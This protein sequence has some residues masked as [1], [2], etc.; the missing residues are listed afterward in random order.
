MDWAPVRF[1]RMPRRPTHPGARRRACWFAARPGAVGC[2]P[3][4]ALLAFL[5]AIVL[6]PAA[7]HAAVDYLKDIKPVLHQ[8][9]LSCHGALRQKAG[10][11]LDTA[12]LVR[13]G[14]SKGVVATPSHPDGSPLLARVTTADPD[15]RMPPDGGPLS[16]EQVSALRQW[17]AE[18]MTG[19]SDEVAEADP[20]EHWSFKKPVRP[21]LPPIQAPD[22]D[23]HPID[24]FV[25]AE[26]EARGLEPV[27]PAT[28]EVLLRRVYIDLVGY[29]PTRDELHAFLV[30][31]SDAAY[32][33]VV[34]RLLASPAHGERWARHWMDVWRYADWFGRRHVPDVWNSAPQ[35]FRWRDW[36]VASLNADKGY[37]QMGRE[38]LAADEVRPGDDEAGVATGYLVRNWYALNPNQWMRETVEHTAK[39]FL[40]L[41][42]NCAHCHDHKYDPITQE[43][44]FRFRAFFEPMGLRQD[45][46]LGEPDPGPFQKYEYSALRRV[47]KTGSVRVLDEAAGAPTRLYRGGDERNVASNVP[48]IRPGV[49]A[50]LGGPALD[51][52][53]VPLPTTAYYPGLR[54]FVRDAEVAAR[55]TALQAAVSNLT[56]LSRALAQGPKPATNEP[57]QRA[58]S[59][60][61]RLSHDLAIDRARARVRAAEADAESLRR[62]IAAAVAAHDGTPPDAAAALASEASRAE[63]HHA[64]CKADEARIAATEA[65]DLLRAEQALARARRAAMATPDKLVKDEAA[66]EEA[67]L[68]KLGEEVAARTQAAQRA[69]ADAA[70]NGVAFTPLSPVYPATSTGRRRAL[71]HWIF[72]KDNPLAAR[73][74]VNHVWMRHFRSPLV[75]TVFDL[76]RNGSPPTHPALLDW[77]AV[78]LME[79]GWSLKHLHR[80]IVT[81]RTYRLASAP[82]PGDPAAAHRNARDPDNAFL[83]RMNPGHMEAEVLRDALLRLAGTLDATIGGYPVPNTEAETSRRRTLYLECFPEDGG[84][85]EFTGMFDPPDPTDCYRRTTTVMPQQALALSN[86]RIARQQAEAI[87]RRLGDD[88]AREDAPHPPGT[89]P[90][91][92]APPHEAHRRFIG[93]AFEHVLGRSPSPSESDAAMRFLASDA[94]ATSASKSVAPHER[95]ASEGEATTADA[96]AR[97]SLVVVLLGHHDFIAVP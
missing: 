94:D 90:A 23:A 29:P 48:P 16:A 83:W 59:A 51:V 30:D 41:T 70:T 11:R 45:R 19:P 66:K 39:A 72:G 14:S 87:A 52:R 13:K 10:L 5:G 33:R 7:A 49:P 77:L 82:H 17:I 93:A 1:R 68:Q 43:D 89:A 34:D 9:C 12:Q 76:G 61:E 47:V 46:W 35:V 96:A 92:P 80:L 85:S 54:D 67:A 24:A 69:L 84:H 8:R 15:E 79:S 91:A 6:L 64:W 32:A 3:T 86:S 50:I 78:E 97:A 4:F 56:A 31:P 21:P 2:A 22:A 38:M 26:R 75:R 28:P 58:I 60:V 27:G 18:G 25:A 88:L 44:Y 20:R 63:R 36:I 40:G 55:G 62:R 81:S 37:D 53:P 95:P 42:F 74:A 65:M 73:V 71:A 57:S